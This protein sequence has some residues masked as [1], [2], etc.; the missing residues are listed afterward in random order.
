MCWVALDRVI[1][2]AEQEHLEADVS[3]W[4][5]VREQIR[6]DILVNGYDPLARLPFAPSGWSTI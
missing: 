3:R 2:A 5:E 6:T 4:R 1:R